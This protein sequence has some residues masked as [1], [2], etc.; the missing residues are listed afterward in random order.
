LTIQTK[1]VPHK[2]TAAAVLPLDD[3]ICPEPMECPDPV[4]DHA[5]FERPALSPVERRLRIINLAAVII[6]FL[7]LIAAIVLT[8]GTAINWVQ[9]AILVGMVHATSI[10]ITI[11]YHRLFTHKSFQANAAVRFTLAVLGSMAVQGAV[12]EW[13]GAHRRHHQHSD[14]HDDPHSPYNYAGRSWGA[15]IVGTLRGFYHA[16]VGWLFEPRLKGMGKYTKDLRAD[17]VIRAV[18]KQFYIWAL[19]GLIVPAVLGGL[20]TMS[21]NGALLGF[22]WGGLV[23]VLIVHHVTWSVNSVCHL[24]GTRPFEC[25]DESRN[26]AIVGVLALG[27]GWHNNHHAFPASARHGLSWWQI[28]I[29]YIYI[30]AMSLVGLVRNI[31][32]PDRDRVIA[33]RDRTKAA[34]V[35]KTATAEKAA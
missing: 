33:K 35:A 28:D 24:W 21:F 14:D 6:P 32:L 7:G 1:A 25:G 19:V 20:L 34:K 4:G 10:G 8:W 23:R 22:L 16:H 3:L 2:P 13:V 9:L 29:S 18:N 12:I 30:R 26:N 11:G 15:G 27:E 5:H 31:R 17:P